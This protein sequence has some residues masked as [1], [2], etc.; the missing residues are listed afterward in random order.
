MEL[1][2]NNIKSNST[3]YAKKAK[4]VSKKNRRSVKARAK[5]GTKKIKKINPIMYLNDVRKYL[6]KLSQYSYSTLEQGDTVNYDK[7]SA[8]AGFIAYDVSKTFREHHDLLTEKKDELSELMASMHMDKEK[9]ND[10]K[11]M[12]DNLLEMSDNGL[13]Y[14]DELNDRLEEFIA[15]YKEIYQSDSS[16]NRI[17]A[18]N[19]FIFAIFLRKTIKSAI[20]SAK[21]HIK[22]EVKSAKAA[23]L[24]KS[25]EM[26]KNARAND[27]LEDLANAFGAV[28]VSESEVDKLAKMF[29]RLLE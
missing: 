18:E 20:K 14:V 16:S 13:D 26:K 17:Q 11:T 22:D 8:I 25:A 1:N 21:V 5:A 15:I 29:N 27:E 19:M 10:I 9:V 24:V 2:T 23:S 28:A 7:L 3:K 12:F 6:S 4:G